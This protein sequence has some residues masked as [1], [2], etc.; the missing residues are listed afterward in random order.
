MSVKTGRAVSSG[1]IRRWEVSRRGPHK[2]HKGFLLFSPPSPQTSFCSLAQS[3]EAVVGLVAGQ[4]SCRAQQVA[5]ERRGEASGPRSQGA[6]PED[7][8]TCRAAEVVKGSAMPSGAAAPPTGDHSPQ[9]NRSRR[10]QTGQRHLWGFSAT[11]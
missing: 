2:R 11:Q 4:R 5:Q 1:S 9:G 7:S 10:V 6:L 3:S 8:S